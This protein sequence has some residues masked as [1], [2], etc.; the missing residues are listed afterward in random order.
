[1]IDLTEYKDLG[2]Y[3]VVELAPYIYNRNSFYFRSH[4]I[5][6]PETVA[7]KKY[8]TDETKKI[9]NGFW[10]LDQKN[11]ISIYN[12]SKT[13]GYRY[14]P[15]PL[16]WYVNYIFI[17]HQLEGTIIPDAILPDLRDIDWYAFYVYLCCE[18]FS[19]FT[20]DKEYTCNELV[21]KYNKTKSTVK[22]TPKELIKWEENKNYIFTDSTYTTLKKY[23]KPLKYLKSTFK[24]PL[25]LPLYHNP[26]KD[27]FDLE[28]R[29]MGKTYRMVALISHKFNFKGA[30]TFEEY[31]NLKAGPTI[32]VGSILSTKSGELL[33]KFKFA[34]DQLAENFGQYE[35]VDEGLFYPGFFYKKTMG[36][37]D[38]GNGKNPYRHRYKIQKNG[39]WVTKGSNTK[40]VHQSYE[41]NPEAF[42]GNRAVYM[43]EDEVGL[44][45]L[46]LKSLQ[47]DA[48]VMIMD[49]KM[50]WAHKT[51]TGGNITKIQSSKSVFYDPRGYGY[52]EFDD[53]WENSSTPIGMF[54]PA[55]YQD[56]TFR[57]PNGNQNLELALKQELHNR[58]LLV[59]SDNIVALDGLIIA[60]PLKPSEMFL[61]P[62]LNIFP[63]TLSRDHLNDILNRKVFESYASIGYLE[64]TDKT[65]NAVKW[66]NY[67]D[68][69][70]K[71][72]TTYD[73]K[74]YDGNIR[75]SIV[76]YEH[77]SDHTPFP[78]HRRSLYKIVYDPIMDDG[79][80]T[81]LGAIIV[82]KGYTD[83]DWNE[84]LQNTIVATFYGR[85]NVEELHEIAIQ[86][87]LYYNAKILP[88]TNI[89]DFIRYC[90]NK[91]KFHLLQVTPFDAISKFLK[92]PSAKYEVG[93]RI[94]K[95]LSIQGEQLGN[96]Y[97]L[98]ERGLNP[99]T[100]KKILNLH[101]IF[102]PR[103]LDEFINY[104]RGQNCDAISAFKLLM[105][106]IFQ[107]Q[108]VPVKATSVQEHRSKLNKFLGIDNNNNINRPL[109]S[110]SSYN[111]NY[112]S[113]TNTFF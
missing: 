62:E 37:L 23:K 12:P 86:L 26:L 45:G 57:D 97:L 92:S 103:L 16:Y 48:T 24:S 1:M 66:V 87:A 38:N 55:T 71:P 113:D 83:G 80:G 19:G 51:G 105:F 31:V 67:K 104:K 11:E 47:A 6:H 65:N 112:S 52:M 9:I 40:I 60:R 72:I 35:D 28:A 43:G 96:Q 42:V 81:S 25:G 56:S 110:G 77:P 78:T 20:D 32:C 59:D 82:H 2:D 98:E 15:G 17:M 4:P 68:P 69:Y 13:G 33:Q 46:L 93:L 27:L 29:G 102:C 49:D 14:M 34:Q 109:S 64:Y 21:A 22:F 107:E 106:W 90:K 91:N 44:N 85:R 88:E 58:K 79:D 94:N 61:S 73:L 53:E 99:T 89:A 39:T 76:I 30:K 36:V 50:G 108:M 70:S 41:N 101:H 111:S 100:N 84:G 63:A 18:G 7:Y 74:P 54:I 75:G 3:K 8:W 95:T 5:L 10:G